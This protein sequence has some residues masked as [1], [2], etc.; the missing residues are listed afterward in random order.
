MCYFCRAETVNSVNKRKSQM[1]YLELNSAKPGAEPVPGVK[2][3]EQVRVRN[4]SPSSHRR[5]PLCM[6]PETSTAPPPTRPTQDAPQPW[7]L[8]GF[9]LDVSQPF[10]GEGDLASD[11]PPPSNS[12]RGRMAC[13][14]L[15]L[16]SVPAFP[17]YLY[18]WASGNPNC[19]DFHCER[20]NRYLR[21][22]SL[23]FLPL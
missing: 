2:C 8:Y 6:R 9:R 1:L 5:C 17:I 21:G 7:R 22:K 14:C 18:Q 4:P 23:F 19:C 3:A 10:R 13:L 15:P 16:L 11:Q 20:A 12:Q